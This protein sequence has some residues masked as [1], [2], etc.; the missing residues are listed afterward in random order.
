VYTRYVLRA[1]A[2]QEPAAENAAT[3]FAPVPL[4]APYVKDARTVAELRIAL[5][6][7][8]LADRLR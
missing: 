4:R 8:R 2:L 7:Y 1:V 6:G 5:A 3:A